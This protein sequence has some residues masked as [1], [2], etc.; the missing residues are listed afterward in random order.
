[1]MSGGMPPMPEAAS[2]FMMPDLSPD[3]MMMMPDMMEMM[4]DS[5]MMSGMMSGM[6][7]EHMCADLPEADAN[8]NEIDVERIL[9]EVKHVPSALRQELIDQ[10][11]QTVG[12]AHLSTVTPTKEKVR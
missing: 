11:V 8:A 6:M 10:V 12:E 4:G 9:E 1:L 2:P 5:S 3:M 7:P